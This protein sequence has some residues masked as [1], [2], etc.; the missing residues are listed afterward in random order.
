VN[1]TAKILVVGAN[2]QDLKIHAAT[3]QNQ[4][5]EVWCACD[6]EQTLALLEIDLP[7]LFLIETGHDDL[8]GYTLCARIKQDPRQRN[9]P[10]I[11]LTTGRTPEEIDRGFAAGGVDFIVKPCHLSEFL[12]RVETHLKLHKL[13]QQVEQMREADIDSNPLTR[14]PGNNTIVAA[15]QEAI[16]TGRDVAVIYTDLDNFKAFNDAYGFSCGDDLLLFNAEVLYTA[17]RKVCED[18]SFLGHIGGDDF[19]MIVPAD[20]M[21]EVG[22]EVIRRFDEGVPSFYNDADRERGYIISIDRQG[23]TNHFPLMSISLGGMVLRDYWF[24]RAVEVAEVCA[25]LK[26]AG[27]NTPGSILQVDRREAQPTSLPE[28][29]VAA[30]PDEEPLI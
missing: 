18:R 29:P 11:F 22:E 23:V 26:H 10:V 21:H 8:D 17:L 4:G 12:A 28:L 9:I 19:V 16:D 20:L 24:S 6:A 7:D 27:K 30:G 25:E 15:I 14:L 3:L 1:N 5:Y 13:L 2:Q